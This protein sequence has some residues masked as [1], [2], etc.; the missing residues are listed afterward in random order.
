MGDVKLQDVA[1]SIDVLLALKELLEHWWAEAECNDDDE[2]L[3]KLATTRSVNT[4]GFSSGLQGE[5]LGHIQLQESITWTVQSLQHPRQQHVV[6]AL[7][8]RFK[9]QVARKKHKI[10]LACQSASGKNNRLWS[11]HLFQ[12]YKKSSIVFGSL[13]Q[14]KRH[15]P[16]PASIK[17]LDIN[18]HKYLLLLQTQ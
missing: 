15:K 18:F 1:L 12:Q 6:L 8:G 2:L 9:G 3:F 4:C 11:M 5:E 17:F 10:P 14:T 13:L 7:K 16:K